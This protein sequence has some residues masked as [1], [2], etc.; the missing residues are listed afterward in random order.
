MPEAS[1]LTT[2][3]S[4]ALT[5]PPH[6][7]VEDDLELVPSDLGH[8]GNGNGNGNG[9]H[10]HPNGNGNGKHGNGNG[11]GHAVYANGASA[12]PANGHAA[13]VNGNGNGNGN[14]H[15]RAT[16]SL[17][18]YTG[19]FERNGNHVA[20]AASNGSIARL[21]VLDIPGELPV[22]LP[23]L[24]AGEANPTSVYLRFGKRAMDVVV[25][26]FCLTLLSPFFLLLALLI[27]IDSRGPV[28]YKSKRLG[29]NGRPFTFYKFRSM[30]VGAHEDRHKVEHLNEKTDG[31]VFKISSDPRTTRM[32]RFIRQTS[33]D[34]L[35][36]LANVLCGQMTLVGPRPPLPE[37]V[38]QYLSWHRR[39]LE[40]KPGITCLWQIS[41]RS[42]LG[43]NE[44]MRLDLEYI[45]RQSFATDVKIL[46][47]TLPA[48]V[49][50]E[51]AY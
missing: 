26:F 16:I 11:N 24:G 29:R 46:V 21:A 3:L 4:V 47:R 38:A 6:E 2:A 33:L 13:Y 35:P 44:W 27:K 23:W 43:F 17:T 37:E 49:S 20:A 36:Q 41:G 5:D 34:E 1:E 28:F 7:L 9:A 50:R 18:G 32:G 40:V 51:G 14:G 31:P 45:K 19:I 42:R 48:V 30:Y 15:A 12:H 10:A 22:A 8:N 39:R 25:S